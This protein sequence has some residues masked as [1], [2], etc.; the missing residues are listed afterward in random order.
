MNNGPLS[1]LV[2]LH[3]DG[4]VQH[5]LVIGKDAPARL[6]IASEGVN[7]IQP[8]DFILWAPSPAECQE[9]G[10]L[11]STAAKI[12]S[13]L[14]MDGLVYALI[15]N[16]WRAQA[17]H[18]LRN[19]GLE[20]ELI[21]AHLPDWSASRYCI[22]LETGPVEYTFTQ[23]FPTKALKRITA[24]AALHWSPGRRLVGLGYPSAA[25]VAR[26]PHSRKLFLWLY[27][28]A[29]IAPQ[30][31]CAS[32]AIKWKGD[33]SSIVIHG[34]S[35]ESEPKIVAKTILTNNRQYETG[36]EYRILENLGPPARQ[37]G[38][39]VPQPLQIELL[40]D[41]PVF[42]QS[43]LPGTCAAS[44]LAGRPNQL[45]ATVER[46]TTWLIA[47]NQATAVQRSLDEPFFTHNFL[48]PLEKVAPHL[49]D[50]TAYRA[51]LLSRCAEFHHPVKL[52]AAHNDLT[53]WNIL[54][55]PG[56]SIGVVDWREAQ[57]AALPLGDF[58][59]LFVDAVAVAHHDNHEKAF[60]ECVE[61]HGR[62]YSLFQDVVNRMTEVLD[63]PTPLVRLSLHAC[64]LHHAANEQL[65]RLPEEDHP[66][67]RI[68]CWLE[69][70][71]Q[72][73]EQVNP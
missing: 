33:C 25:F 4:F 56:G 13:L 39:A 6:S 5:A 2:F 12:R 51:W 8:V 41:C 46:I 35:E 49:A 44:A 21:M 61:P 70:N 11:Q 37:S 52:T 26:L 50:C 45:K 29:D 32:M 57:P 47:W 64:F 58:F 38:A 23:Q 28:Q 63:L 66:F 18:A 24:L 17:Q 27:R 14:A 42:L 16:R 34:Y 55:Q 22:P 65:E 40:G 62:Y 72:A 43:F 53:L 10:G 20:I 31:G 67:L 7:N 69:E 3:P 15:P 1:P 36:N 68:L 73:L 60:L 9:P 59:Y 19:E 54:L 48:S 30:T 71:R